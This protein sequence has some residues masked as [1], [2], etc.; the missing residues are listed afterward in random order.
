MSLL[1]AVTLLASLI[2]LGGCEPTRVT[3]R[4]GDP[5]QVQIQVET[6]LIV[7]ADPQ[8]A[9]KINALELPA[10]TYI[11]QDAHLAPIQA[12]PQQP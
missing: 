8:T 12:N 9:R 2:L 5:I 7:P 10:G 11:L 1:R 4:A 6:A 3:I